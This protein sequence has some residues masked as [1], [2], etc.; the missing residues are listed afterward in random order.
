MP[1]KKALRFIRTTAFLF[2]VCIRNSTHKIAA[3]NLAGKK[4]RCFI[5]N[6]I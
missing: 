6:H 1:E 3:K 2:V 4:E 5:V